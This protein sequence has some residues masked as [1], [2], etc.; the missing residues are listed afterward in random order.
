MKKII[1]RGNRPLRGDVVIN[2]MK[3]AA[4]PILFASILVRGTSRLENIPPVG[5][6]MVALDILSGMGADVRR[7]DYSTFEI[8][9]DHLV[10]GTSR[11]D[12][13]GK[14]RGSSY[15]LGAELGRFG[16]AAVAFP[17]GCNFGSRPL[18]L[19]IKGFETLGARHINEGGFLRL[20]APEGL[21][22]TSVYFDFASVGATVNMILA[23]VLV[24]GTTVIENA[25]REPHI[26]D[27][28]SYLNSCGANITGAGTSVIK[29]H[30][31]SE[32]HACTYAIIPD[33]IE[34]GSYMIAAAATRGCVRIRSVIPKHVETVSTK[35]REMGA[36]VEE[37]DDSVLVSAEEMP[38]RNVTVKTLP[39]P[40]FATDLQS[41]IAPLLCVAGGASYIQ[42]GV[43]EGRFRYVDELI[44]MGA[45]IRVDGRTATFLG[46][47][48]LVGAR[49]SACDMRAGVALV[50]AGLMA[51]GTT[52]ISGVEM[53]YRGYDSIVEK[54][55]NL[56]ADISEQIIPSE[57]EELIRA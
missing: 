35:L 14:I 3:N 49:V 10:G 43:F 15:L 2:G 57:E 56:G 9:T 42:E 17:G 55:R 53:I 16:K 29:I 1:I 44:K 45:D 39:Y 11:P 20:D 46:V 27:L 33:M 23:S 34:A 54:F 21:T 48:N 22:G 26:V 28:A 41:P 4:L 50:I 24:E 40:G 19:H 25:A 47:P 13:V 12:L 31:V 7:V 37:Q 32:L 36:V 8:N 18:D 52:E 6:I 51:E 5:D 38:F 30:G